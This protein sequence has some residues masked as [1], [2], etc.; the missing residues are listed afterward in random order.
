MLARSLK[1]QSTDRHTFTNVVQIFPEDEIEKLSQ[2]QDIPILA[3]IPL[4]SVSSVKPV[5]C[6]LPREN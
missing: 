1:Q 3:K 2:E 6:D 5:L 4:D